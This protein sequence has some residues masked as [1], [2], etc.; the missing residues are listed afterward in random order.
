MTAPARRGVSDT[1]A[2][3]T[4]ALV[5]ILPI[6]GGLLRLTTPGWL[7]VFGAVI[8][9]PVVVAGWVVLTI[10]LRPGGRLRRGPEPVP[11]GLVALAWVWVGSVTLVNLLLPD[12]G[13]SGPGNAPIAAVFGAQLSDGAQSALMGV[14]PIGMLAAIG[15]GIG[16]LALLITETGRRRAAS[17]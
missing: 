3:A 9:V 13:D 6:V 2:S 10:A 7:L 16:A 8:A 1:L 12:G 5:W 4:L 11:T 15:S 17:A 14:A